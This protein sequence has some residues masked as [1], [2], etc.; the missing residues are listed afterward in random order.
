MAE[1]REYIDAERATRQAWGR[2]YKATVDALALEAVLHQ[3]V[4][5][6]DLT[7]SLPEYSAGIALFAGADVAMR[8]AFAGGVA[9]MEAVQAAGAAVGANVFPGVPVPVAEDNE[10]E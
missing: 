7:E 9:I 3:R 5:A 1:T 6:G 4:T 2:V 8:Q 10:P